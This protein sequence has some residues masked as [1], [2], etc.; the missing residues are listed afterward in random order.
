MGSTLKGKSLLNSANAK[1]HILTH[2][3][4]FLWAARLTS[5][6]RETVNPFVIGLFIPSRSIFSFFL[7]SH[8]GSV[9]ARAH[10]PLV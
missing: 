9:L 2:I 1:T 7:F 4:T 3:M 10:S 6:G 5:G 8:S